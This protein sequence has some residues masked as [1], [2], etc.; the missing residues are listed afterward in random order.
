M[1]YI[2]TYNEYYYLNESFLSDVKNKLQSITDK[3]RLKDYLA[4][5]FEQSEKMNRRFKR[6][7]I[8]S[9]IFFVLTTSLLKSQEILQL[10]GGFSM[11][12]QEIVE[13]ELGKENLLDSIAWQESTNRP[14]IVNRL[15]YIGKYQF[16]DLALVDAGVVKNKSQARKFRNK[17]ISASSSER[18]KMWTEEEQDKAMI[19]LMKKNKH[20]LRNFEKFVGQ[21]IN[22]IEITWSGLL[23]AAHLGGQ[24][25]VKKF[26]NSDGK[27]DYADANGTKI[28][29]YLS[30]FSGYK[31]NN[32]IK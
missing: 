29:E 3:E 24:G 31:I 19:N 25:N 14:D 18:L 4:S 5:L 10:I 26:L 7:F 11:D 1:Q 17:F 30:K 21:V 2:Q 23:M 22:G 8:S 20:Y 15:G 9:I 12:T 6:I 28:S 13:E 16:H 32:L 27:Y